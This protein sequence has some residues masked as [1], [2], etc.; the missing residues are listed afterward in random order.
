MFIAV[1]FLLHCG[2]EETFFWYLCSWLLTLILPI[3]SLRVG[4]SQVLMTPTHEGSSNNTGCQCA[5]TGSGIT[6]EGSLNSR[7]R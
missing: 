7:L 6:P 4:A 3:H 2:M 1:F 5:Q